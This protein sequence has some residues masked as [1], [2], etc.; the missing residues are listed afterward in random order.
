MTPLKVE[1]T[2]LVLLASDYFE[3]QFS[4]NKLTLVKL[5]IPPPMKRTLPSLCMGARSMRSRTVRA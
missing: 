5:A 2:C 3:T 1:A 4:G